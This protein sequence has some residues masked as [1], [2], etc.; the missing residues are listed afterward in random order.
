MSTHLFLSPHF[1]DAI[2]S[3]GGLIARQTGHG[4]RVFVATLCA[5]QPGDGPFSPF[6]DFQHKRWLAEH[7]GADPNV[8]RRC[9]DEAACAVAGAEPVFLDD[10]DCIYRRGNGAWLYA[11]E[12]AL[13]GPLHPADDDSALRAALM[14]LVATLA[15]D[16]I[17]APLAAGNHVDHQRVR[18]IAEEWA[19]A[20]Q[21]IYFYEDYPYVE[22]VERL[23]QALNRP[24]SGRWRRCHAPLS[25]AEVETKIRAISCYSSQMTV[26]FQDEM[27]RRVRAQ[28]ACTG[29]PNLAEALWQ[30][31][32][33]SQEQA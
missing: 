8:L 16:T 2:L 7:P 27:P 23:W 4:D 31:K 21:P 28:L 18:R 29:A 30:L 22:Q 9:E 32:S 20:G 15:P 19:A 17:Y 5:G 33:Q 12:Q 24:I 14:D 13:F 1:D 11:S 25:P 10:L 6:A 26:L 3:C